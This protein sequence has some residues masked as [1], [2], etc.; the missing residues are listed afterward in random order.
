MTIVWPWRGVAP[1]RFW[2]NHQEIKVLLQVKH[3]PRAY[4]SRRYTLRAA[5]FRA[6]AMRSVFAPGG[7]SLP[8]DRIH[9]K[10]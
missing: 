4:F 3:G 1:Q 6:D 10:L 7:G 8:S 9:S 5:Q 2:L